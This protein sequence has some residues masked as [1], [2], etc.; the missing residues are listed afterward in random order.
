M[1]SL[2]AKGAAGI[3]RSPK[4]ASLLNCAGIIGMALYRP[5]FYS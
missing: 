1:A 3:H 4:A 2:S 5:P